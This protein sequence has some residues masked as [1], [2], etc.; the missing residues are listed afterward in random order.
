MKTLYSRNVTR[1]KVIGISGSPFASRFKKTEWLLIKS[2]EAVRSEGLET[3]LVKLRDFSLKLCDGCDKCVR[4]KKCPFDEE[5]DMP[6]L[7]E[8]LLSCKGIIIASPTYF[9]SVSGMVKNFMD[10][11]RPLRMRNLPLKNKV[12]GGVTTAGWR[13]GGQEAVLDTIIHFCLTHGMIVVGSLIDL[14]AEQSTPFGGIG[15]V[16]TMETSRWKPLTQDAVGTQAAVNLGKRV[17]EV[18]KIMAS[19]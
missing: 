18:I 13:S 6:K 14:G 11:T 1:L 17:A 5:D 9:A 8:K 12:G 16:Q 4:E 10:R 2:L 3:D 19:S 15:T 7:Y